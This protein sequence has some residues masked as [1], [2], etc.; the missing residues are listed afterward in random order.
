MKKFVMH[1]LLVLG[2]IMFFVLVGFVGYDEDHYTREAKIVDIRG[3]VVYVVDNK[4]YYW[5]FD[6][7][8]ISVDINID[9]KVELLMCANHTSDISD[10]IID[11]VAL[12]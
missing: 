3:K 8:E 12:L 6:S 10:D 4:G 9:D 5:S 11:K 2:F 1:M 7:S